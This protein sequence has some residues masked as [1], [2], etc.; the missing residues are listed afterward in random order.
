MLRRVARNCTTSLHSRD[1]AIESSSCGSSTGGKKQGSALA[2]CW[3]DQRPIFGT[4]RAGKY[5]AIS[6]DMSKSIAT[7]RGKWVDK[8]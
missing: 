7:V 3:Q 8:R 5:Q 4:C 1:L 2:P 6:I